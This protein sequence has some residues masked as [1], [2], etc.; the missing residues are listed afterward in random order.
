MRTLLFD[1]DGTLLLTNRGGGRA[2]FQAIREEFG[3]SEVRMD[4]RFS[5][6]T[7]RSLL[8]EILERNELEPSEVNQ[9]R[10]RDI[11][12]GLLPGV[13]Q[14]HGGRVLPGATE[15]LDRIS[16]ETEVRCYVMTGNLHET[17]AHKL[18]HFGLGHYFRGIFGG[19]HDRER[20]D[21]ARRTA[22]ALRSRYGQ[23]ATDD[24][25]VI[26]DTP[27]DIRCGH[28]IGARVV[29]VCTGNYER[30]D[31]EAE[32]PIVVLDDMSDVSTI[33]GLLTG[34]NGFALGHP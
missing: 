27:A 21:L 20:D 1:I 19:D 25:V 29:A 8:I 12:T 14:R 31:L 2:L 9:A 24:V 7:D 11:Y 32:K 16:A 4:I 33:F 5:G 28:A 3:V 15:L 22:E 18:N 13:L 17:A 34:A 26:G 30:R 10:L 6:R 23:S